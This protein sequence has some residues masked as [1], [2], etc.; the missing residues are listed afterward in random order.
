MKL[1]FVIKCNYCFAHVLAARLRRLH[2]GPWTFSTA[3]RTDGYDY[4]FYG[5]TV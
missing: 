5:G 3:S 1:A 2:N 4:V